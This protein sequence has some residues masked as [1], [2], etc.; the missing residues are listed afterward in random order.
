MFFGTGEK[1]NRLEGSGNQ[2]TFGGAVTEWVKTLRLPR[3]AVAGRHTKARD[4]IAHHNES[5]CH[6]FFFWIFD[7]AFLMRQYIFDYVRH[8]T[9]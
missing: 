6:R 1:G 4:R 2:S 9:F 7:E 8:W 3:T 5:C